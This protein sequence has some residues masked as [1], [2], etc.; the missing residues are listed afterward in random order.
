MDLL[1]PFFDQV[2]HIQFQHAE[3]D[4]DMNRLRGN[5]RYETMVAA[6]RERLAAADELEAKPAKG[7]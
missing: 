6:A 5:S 4:P 1:G 3:V 7:V 2:T